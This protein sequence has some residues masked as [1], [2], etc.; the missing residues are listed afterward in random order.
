M[1]VLFILCYSVA[2]KAQA[3]IIT[4]GVPVA[5]NKSPEYAQELC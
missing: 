5:T 4:G 3:Y 2:R 1:K